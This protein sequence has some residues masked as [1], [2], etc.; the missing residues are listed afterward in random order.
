MKI[1]KEKSDKVLVP[2][3]IR[4]PEKLVEELTK[5]AEKNDLSRQKLITAIF[6]KALSDKT[7]QVRIKE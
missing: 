7:F 2:L 4:I 6:E 3:T 5:L 1:V